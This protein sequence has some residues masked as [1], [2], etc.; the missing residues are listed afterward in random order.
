MPAVLRGY[1]SAHSFE[2][3]AHDAAGAFHTHEQLPN[4]KT[5]NQ[6]WDIVLSACLSTGRRTAYAGGAAG[7]FLRAFVRVGG[8]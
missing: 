7:I 6:G 2:L 1:F 4:D 8:T 5:E 3:V